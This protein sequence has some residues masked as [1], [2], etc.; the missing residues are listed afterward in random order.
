MHVYGLVCVW[1]QWVSRTICHIWVISYH[2]KQ[3]VSLICS[4]AMGRVAC[5][6][7][8][9]QPN[10]LLYP[11]AHDTKASKLSFGVSVLLCCDTSGYDCDWHSLRVL[12][13]YYRRGH[14][15]VLL[16][17]ATP[18]GTS[19]QVLKGMR[20]TLYVNVSGKK[21]LFTTSSSRRYAAEND[22]IA[23]IQ[24]PLMGDTAAVPMASPKDPLMKD[25]WAAWDAIPT[26]QVRIIIWSAIV[27]H[28]FLCV[29]VCGVCVRCVWCDVCGVTGGSGCR[30]QQ[31]ERRKVWHVRMR[32]EQMCGLFKETEFAKM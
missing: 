29:C 5:A 15:S 24:V 8:M 18:H 32:Y 16:I 1:F 12:N 11:W 19:A 6:E 13:P 27:S 30:R 26:A 25:G 9:S 14:P 31:R 4:M 20:Q 7:C 2:R 3:V 17:V 23:I 28:I 10:S 21:G 22:W